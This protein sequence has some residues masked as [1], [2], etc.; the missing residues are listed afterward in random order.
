MRDLI[1]ALTLIIAGFLG[2]LVVERIVLWRLK[3]L[4][5]RTKWRFD[6]L[7]TQ[8]TH[9]MAILFGGLLGIR[10]AIPYLPLSPALSDIIAKIILVMILLALTIV[11]AR[12]L[13]G[14]VT[15]YA[16]SAVPATTSIF[17]NLI[18]I[19]VLILGIL[20]IFQTLGINITPVVTA[21]GI[22]GLAVA[23]ALQDTLANLF[24]GLHILAV[25]Q[26]NPGDYVK[27]ESAEEGYITDIGWR[28]TTIRMLR[29]NLIIVPNTKI[30]SSIITNYFLP[31]KQ[32]SVLIEVGVSYD[33]DLE[34][35]ERVTIEVARNIMRE[36][37]GGVT[38]FEPFIR[39]HTFDDF[40]INF[41]VILRSSEFVDQYLIKH[42]FI[43]KLHERYQQEGIEIPFPIRTVHMRQGAK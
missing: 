22:G 37:S 42:E 17:K 18:N 4:A 15:Y 16:S 36:I 7:A 31:E 6:D 43:K 8:V 10:A 14:V 20:V 1:I 5:K 41:S 23:L 32:M 40:S 21:L 34:K 35:V 28:N 24:A 30:A 9:G 39:Y 29:N 25:K 27:L 2:G 11:A 26:I 38:E 33:S 12:F 13:S 19:I 3:K